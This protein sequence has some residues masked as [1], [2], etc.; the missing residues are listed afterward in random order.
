[1]AGL[2]HLTLESGGER[3]YIA[4]PDAATSTL[5]VLEVFLTQSEQTDSQDI[6]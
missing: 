2:V 6:G 5:S 1:M 4:R 3:R